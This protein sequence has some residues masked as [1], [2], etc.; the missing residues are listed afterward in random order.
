MIFD[1]SRPII[2]RISF[3]LI[4]IVIL[5]DGKTNIQPICHVQSY[6]RD[7]SGML[8]QVILAFTYGHVDDYLVWIE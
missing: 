5:H 4:Y 2:Y 7:E 6:S 1:C 8:T 3:N